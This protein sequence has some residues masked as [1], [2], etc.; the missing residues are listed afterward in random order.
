[1]SSDL[2]QL[3]L[4]EGYSISTRNTISYIVSSLSIL[5][6]IFILVVYLLLKEL[7]SKTLYKLVFNLTVS[8][9]VAT[10]AGIYVPEDVETNKHASSYCQLAGF[11]HEYG[12]L[13][14]LCWSAAFAIKIYG[15]VVNAES[16][17]DTVKLK[18][19]YLGC[20][21]LPFTFCLALQTAAYWTKTQ[22]FGFNGTYCWLIDDLNEVQYILQTVGFFLPSIIVSIGTGILYF[23]IRNTLIKLGLEV[24]WPFHFMLYPLMILLLMIPSMVDQAVILIQGGD[25][26]PILHYIRVGASQSVTFWNAAT[27]GLTKG[28]RNELRN[29]CPC[30]NNKNSELG[31]TLRDTN[32]SK[33]RSRHASHMEDYTMDC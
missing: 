2:E 1:M 5:G 23:R 7:R 25:G 16:L 32:D 24:K 6:G 31:S 18:N 17:E 27:Y 3:Q 30:V 4:E 20:F 9:M 19:V 26:L 29:Y 14:T 10:L 33:D 12:S 28:V 22:L 8:S 21:V 11:F 13:S 15:L